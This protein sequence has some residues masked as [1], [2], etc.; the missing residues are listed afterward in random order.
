MKRIAG[1]LPKAIFIEKGVEKAPLARRVIKN[2]GDVPIVTVGG[3]REAAER[4]AGGGDPVGEGKQVIYLAR[5][6]GSFIKPCPCTPHYVGCNYFIINSVLNCP[7]DCTYCILQLYLG[8][9]PLTVFCNRE[10]LWTELDRLLRKNRGRP[11]RIGTGELSDSLALDHLT[12]ASGELIS[13]FRTR[14]GAVLELKTKTAAVEHVLRSRPAENVVVSWSLNPHALARSDERGAAPARDRLDAAGEVARRGFQVGFHFDPLVLF[15]GWEEAYGRLVDSLFRAVPA[16][17]IRWISLGSLRFPPALRGVI[18]TR[19][20]RSRLIYAELLPGRDGKLRYFKPL[21]LEL[22]RRTVEMIRNGGGR[23]VPLYFCMEDQE[24]WE[25][26]LK[27]RPRRKAEVELSL[28]PRSVGSK[29][30][31]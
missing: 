18:E 3:R 30:I 28:S 15:R 10:D 23:D 2:S 19:F 8:G 5:Q 17:R 24:V 7:L 4:A 26:V 6:N 9:G 11:L 13:Y 25:R 21:R 14:P 20:P 31:L 22:Y 1:F 12:E 29:S 27:W 16:R